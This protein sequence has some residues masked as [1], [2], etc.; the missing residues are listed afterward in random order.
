MAKW[1]EFKKIEKQSGRKA[2]I[3][4]VYSK[5]HNFELGLIMW[6][7]PWR[8]YAFFPSIKTLYEKVCLR[9]IA[10]F[11]ETETKKY[12]AEKKAASRCCKV[13]A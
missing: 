1:I 9:D 5:E 10:E 6:H 7:G 8:G 3:W 2:D 11:L 13:S 4:A 12:L